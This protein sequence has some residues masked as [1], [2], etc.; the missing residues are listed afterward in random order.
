METEDAIDQIRREFAGIAGEVVAHLELALEA[1]EDDRDVSDDLR[2]RDAR[3][4]RRSRE[5]EEMVL[6][7][8]MRFSEFAFAQ[9]R[10]FLDAMVVEAV[11]LERVGNLAAELARHVARARRPG[12]SPMATSPDLRVVAGV[13]VAALQGA[14]E[15]F[16]RGDVAQADAA[17][18][19]AADGARGADAVLTALMET[20]VPGADEWRAHMLLAARCV[21]RIAANASGLAE[22]TLWVAGAP[23]HRTRT[24]S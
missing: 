2:T 23:P 5:L 15:A 9:R 3:I 16:T 8:N 22:R 10:R 24:A 19:R 21:E 6:R 18:E 13:A 1:W 11:A 17:A 4:D 20:T 12:G 7:A 14:C